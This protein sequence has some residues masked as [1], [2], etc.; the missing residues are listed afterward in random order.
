MG[1]IVI[2]TYQPKAGQAEALDA[3][4]RDH[5]PTL[6]ALGLATDRAPILMRAADGAVLEV[7]EWVEGGSAR[8]HGVP[9]VLALW[10]RF[11]S[12]CDFTTLRDIPESADMFATFKPL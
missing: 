6:R 2:V 7:F 1:E 12:A 5:V 3:L 11:S 4:V 10:E 9:E 8:A